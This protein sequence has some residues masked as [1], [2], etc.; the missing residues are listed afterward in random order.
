MLPRR[1]TSMEGRR[2]MAWALAYRTAPLISIRGSMEIKKTQKYFFATVQFLIM[3]M[4]RV[5][6]III[7]LLALQF[8]ELAQGEIREEDNLRRL[9]RISL[10]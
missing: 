2:G 7:T 10:A 4:V 5:I 6:V 8:Q 9:G 3:V 1:P